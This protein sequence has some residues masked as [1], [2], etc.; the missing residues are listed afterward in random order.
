M[1]H[2][3][4]VGGLSQKVLDL[5]VKKKITWNKNG[6]KQIGCRIRISSWAHPTTSLLAR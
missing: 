1:M 5:L 6:A 3:L 4:L 2:N